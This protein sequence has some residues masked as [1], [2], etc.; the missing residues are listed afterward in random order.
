MSIAS[1]LAKLERGLQPYALPMAE[2]VPLLAALL[3]VPLPEGRY[4]ALPLS[5][6]GLVPYLLAHTGNDHHEG[7]QGLSER[8]GAFGD[9][10][11][12]EAV[13]GVIGGQR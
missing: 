4:P 8:Q 13:D 7:P 9:T 10:R 1:R 5:S 12:S 6:N 2:G 3:A 11:G